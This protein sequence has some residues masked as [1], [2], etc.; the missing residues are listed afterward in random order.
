MY[1]GEVALKHK[2]RKQVY[3]YIRSYP[4]VS[5]S[6]IKKVLDINTSTLK[7]H[8]HYLEK[9]KKIVSKLEGNQ[10]CYYSDV[11]ADPYENTQ[12]KG[13]NK[14]LTKT[15]KRILELIQIQ[16]GVTKNELRLKTKLNRNTLNY[17]L[18]K[19][20]DLKLVWLVKNDGVIGYEYITKE[21][22]RDE[23]FNHLIY[24]LVSK[25]ID[26]ETYHRIKKRLEELDDDEL[27]E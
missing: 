21:S 23:I 20:L 7:Y 11:K 12:L 9:S 18:N 6:A 24:K 8:L 5:F 13:E 22:L 17:N 16:P 19:L 25:E 4:G 1:D 14:E 2:S 10:R 15:Q 27:K 3:N 26:E